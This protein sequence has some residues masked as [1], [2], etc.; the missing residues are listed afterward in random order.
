M[1]FFLFCQRFAIHCPPDGQLD[2]RCGPIR[3]NKE[4][5]QLTK[6]NGHFMGLPPPPLHRN[7]EI[8]ARKFL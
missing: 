4:L 8:L 1:C 5:H 7:F 2:F 6:H 3:I